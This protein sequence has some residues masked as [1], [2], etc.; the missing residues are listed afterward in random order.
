MSDTRTGY[1]AVDAVYK[2]SVSCQPL[3]LLFRGCENVRLNGISE[4]SV[5]L[6]ARFFAL[7]DPA[8]A[9]Q[10]FLLKSGIYR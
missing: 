1:R 4:S 7:A 3:N 8:A 2:K 9:G 5:I 6:S 10:A